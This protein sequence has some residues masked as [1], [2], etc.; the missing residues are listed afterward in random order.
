M[1]RPIVVLS[2]NDGCVIARSDEAKALGIQ[3]GV[4]LFKIRDVVV[5]NNVHVCSSNFALYGDMSRRVMDVIQSHIQDVEI[6]SIDEAFVQFPSHTTLEEALEWGRGL[7]STILQWTGIPTRVGIGATK[8]LAKLGNAMAKSVVGGVCSVDASNPRVFQDFPIKTIWGF[9][10][11]LEKRLK[12]YGIHTVGQLMQRNREWVR[13]VLT[14]VGERTYYELQGIVCYPLSEGVEDDQKTMMVT[15]S[16][17][18]DVID[19]TTLME[20]LIHHANAAGAKL[21]RRGLWTYNVGVYIR[22]SPFKQGYYSNYA[23]IE[24]REPTQDTRLLIHHAQQALRQIYKPGIQYKK[25]GIMLGH[26]TAD[27]SRH[28]YDLLQDIPDILGQGGIKEENRA[29]LMNA[30]DGLSQRYGRYCVSVGAVP[31]RTT[32]WQGTRNHTSPKYTTRWSE[33]MKV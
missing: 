16:F 10:H 23:S 33:L 17:G 4:P 29:S 26:L 1:G 18:S 32:K 2:S 15:R 28:Q 13:K 5:W 7:R 22:S 30:I 14:V 27:P 31:K 20:S 3:M 19:E 24:L 9:G 12:R 6:Y 8:T 25:S 11:Q 21:R